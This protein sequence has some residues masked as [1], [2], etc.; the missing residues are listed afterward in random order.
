MP[1]PN[2]I[3]ITADA[4]RWDCLGCVGNPDVRTPNIDALAAHGVR[5]TQAMCPCPR[6]IPARMTLLTGR[7]PWAHGI[8]EERA[9]VPQNTPTLPRV[10]RDAGY[11]TAAIGQMRFVPTRA[12][13]GFDTMRLAERDRTSRQEDDYH[14]WLAKQGYRDRIDE[15][16]QVNREDAPV[17]YWKSFGAMRSNLPEEC[18]STAWVGREAVRYVQQAREP[19]FLWLSFIKPHH[20]F[21][22]PRPWDRMYDP[23]ALQLPPGFCV[24]PPEQDLRREAALFDMREMTEPRFRKVLAYY[25]ANISHVDQQVGRLLATLTAR[26][27]TNNIVVFCA[28]HGDYMGQHGLIGKTGAPCYDSLLRVPLIVAGIPGQRRGETDSALA[29]LADVAPTL[30]DAAGVPAPRGLSGLSL[31]PA[32]VDGAVHPREAGRALCGPSRIARTRTVKLIAAPDSTDCACFD[33]E[34]DPHEFENHHQD[35]AFAKVRAQLAALLPPAP[36]RE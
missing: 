27:N 21:D 16:D 29:E 33:L 34:N 12:Q 25:Y 4:L 11:A 31:L 9:G 8:T 5:F 17:T 22:P 19:F 2:I 7:Q 24:P 23:K 13:Y 36:P 10:L 6:G 14:V 1:Q 28:G 20:P 15:Y 35:R 32:L 3:L 18:T 26:G 30:L